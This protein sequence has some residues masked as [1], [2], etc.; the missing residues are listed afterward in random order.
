MASN[1]SLLIHDDYMRRKYED[2]SDEE[3]GK[4][5]D[6]GQLKF[7]KTSKVLNG[8]PAKKTA[9]NL[10]NGNSLAKGKE[11][12]AL[13]ILPRSEK[14]PYKLN[15]DHDVSIPASINQY[16]HQYQRE[17]VSFLWNHY[18]QHKGCILADDMGLGKTIQVLALFAAVL[19]SKPKNPPIF[20]VVAPTSVLYNWQD[21]MDVWLNIRVGMFH[22][23]NKQE[24]IDQ[25]KNKEFDVILTTHET[26]RIYFD[27]VSQ[28]LWSAV[29]FDEVHRIKEETSQLTQTSKELPSLC[30]I[31]LTGTPLQNNLKELWCLLDWANPGCLGSSKAFEERFERPI[32]FGQRLDATKRELAT[33]R[34][35]QQELALLHSDWMLRRTKENHLHELPRKDEKIVFCP[36][37]PLQK[38]IYEEILKL[39]K[40]KMLLLLDKKCRCGS[41][42]NGRRCCLKRFNWRKIMFP[43]IQLFLKLS[44]HTA[45]LFPSPISHDRKTNRVNSELNMEVF[46]HLQKM[47]PRFKELSSG[48][49]NLFANLSS[50]ELCGKMAVLH[51]LMTSLLSKGDKILLFSNSTR[52]L[53]ILETYIASRG[54]LTR[55]IDGSTAPKQRHYIMKEFNNNPELSVC[56]LS[57][58]AGALGMNFTGANVV[59][60]FDPCW[61]PTFEQQAQDRAYRIGQRRNVSV[62]RLISVGTIE[63]NM[64]MRQIYKQQ[65]SNIAIEMS[66]ESR[67]FTGVANNV[68]HHGELFG[69]S[70]MFRFSADHTSGFAKE[71][72]GKTKQIEND[73]AMA[74]YQSPVSRKKPSQRVKP[75]PR[76]QPLEDSD[77]DY[78]QDATQCAD[79]ILTNDDG[80]SE[81]EEVEWCDQVEAELDQLLGSCDVSLAPTA[82]H[83]VGA[84][85]HEEKLSNK[86]ISDVFWKGK[87]SQDFANK[88]ESQESQDVC[89]GSKE[90]PQAID[91]RDF[92]P[93]PATARMR[94]KHM[95]ERIGNT[96]FMI[97]STPKSIMGEH[98]E[99]L[100]KMNGV[101]VEKL[102]DFILNQSEAESKK[103]LRDYYVNKEPNLRLVSSFDKIYGNDE[104]KFTTLVDGDYDTK[105][106]LLRGNS[107][108]NSKRPPARR[109]N[110]HSKTKDF[111]SLLDKD[112]DLIK[113]FRKERKKVTSPIEK[114]FDHFSK[115][116]ILGS[117]KLKRKIDNSSKTC[118]RPDIHNHPFAAFEKIRESFHKKETQIIDDWSS[119]EEN[120]SKRNEKSVPREGETS[121]RTPKSYHKL[122]PALNNTPKVTRKSGATIKVENT[123]EDYKSQKTFGNFSTPKSAIPETL[124]N[125]GSILDELL[126]NDSPYKPKRV[127][128]DSNQNTNHGQRLLEKLP[129]SREQ[130][131]IKQELSSS[132]TTPERIF[133]K[134]RDSLNNKSR[135]QSPLINLEPNTSILDNILGIK[136]PRKP[137]S[138][139]I[140]PDS[141]DN[142]NSPEESFFK[143]P[144]NTKKIG[145]IVPTCFPESPIPRNRFGTTNLD[146][147]S[148]GKY[149]P[150]KK[151][152]DPTIF[153]EEGKSI[154]DELLNLD[155]KPRRRV[156]TSD[157]RTSCHRDEDVITS[158]CHGNRN[159]A[160]AMTPKRTLNK[161]PNT[162]SILDQF[163]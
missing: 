42:R 76:H 48:G 13:D 72:F 100:A 109:K 15:E 112:N 91:N 34:K 147:G 135:T 3:T 20:L 111:S 50:F 115:I 93:L 161:L 6:F 94:E 62:Y 156:G 45:L 18:C 61:N 23:K 87:N 55:R 128:S 57:T 28:I 44:N 158:N 67:Y 51:K 124:I 84:S 58:K 8:S 148:M 63:E 22:R 123:L 17:G 27:M 46:E 98:F 96:M 5:L 133:T 146:K 138:N 139:R 64:Y 47:F 40:C 52:L 70:N 56:L 108:L 126:A 143:S 68:E 141:L 113:S 107:S 102:A 99:E 110:H 104:N 121:K 1:K 159:V 117:N 33:A 103:M 132:V 89:L 137:N 26:M 151:L 142:E 16:L 134:Q 83:L 155:A 86:A 25:A 152:Y 77:D 53:N 19:E 12:P 29:I 116:D 101:S 154:L 153:L 81:N 4:I 163:L 32:M 131:F 11:K 105:H 162:T 140:I 127:K 38:A 150:S 118:S 65:L 36:V 39:P 37:S 71:V 21:E 35:K 30:R 106:G 59:I 88:E 14:V 144:R 149:S 60:I 43:F 7:K 10:K 85:R 49:A 90:E 54:I 125:G 157:S 80:D 145:K 41:G 78:T 114:Q 119:D 122:T 2:L 97:G 73:V 9:Q 82:K 24:I 31:G 75:N 79:D 120:E 74:R 66:T 92:K 95:F 129:K 136:S 69:V 160:K 130:S